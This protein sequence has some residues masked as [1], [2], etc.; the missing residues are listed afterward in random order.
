[1][2]N[3]SCGSEGVNTRLTMAREELVRV[4]VRAYVDVCG[5][6]CL[7]VRAC[8]CVDVRVRVRAYTRLRLCTCV[9]LFQ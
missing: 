4:R 3:N 5:R 1:M 7:Y 2:L 8:V 9:I 6:V